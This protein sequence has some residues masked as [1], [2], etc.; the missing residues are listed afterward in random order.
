MAGRHDLFGPE[1][2]KYGDSVFRLLGRSAHRRRKLLVAL[3]KP[4]GGD[5]RPIFGFVNWPILPTWP[6]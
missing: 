6:I 1:R 3:F 2:V 4:L 5:R